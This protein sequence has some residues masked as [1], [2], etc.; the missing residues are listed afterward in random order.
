MSK[1]ISTIILTAVMLGQVAQ[2]AWAQRRGGGGGARAS[3][4]QRSAGGRQSYTGPRGGTAQTYSG[5]RGQAAQVTGP[6][7][8]TATGA[9]GNYGGAAV[10]GSEGGAA[11]RTPQGGAAVRGPEGNAAARGAYGGAAARGPYGNTA[12]RGPYGGTYARNSYAYGGR[13]YYRPA[14]NA[15]Q[16]NVYSRGFYGYPGWHS[17]GYGYYGLAPGL[18]AFTGLAFLSA[19]M[20]IGTYAQ[21]EKTV[22][23]YVVKEGDQ[24]MEVRV[25][26]KGNVISKKPA[27]Q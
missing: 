19:G 26:D 11:A 13:N 20:L 1:K 5:S 6:G 27:Q 21:Q 24:N 8:R 10:R 12:A 23:V 4:A 16:V 7:G 15:N 18:R 9:R 17:Y 2:P 14:W 3:G 22:Y 25:D